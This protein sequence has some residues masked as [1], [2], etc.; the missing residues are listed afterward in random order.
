[1]PSGGVTCE[2]VSTNRIVVGNRKL[3]PT[4]TSEAA[5]VPT[6]YKM[7][8]LLMLL[9]WFSCLV[10]KA[11]MTK[12]KTKIGAIAF[13]AP[14]KRVP[15]M[16]IAVQVGTETPK[17]APPIIPITIFWIKYC[18]IRN[19]CCTGRIVHDYA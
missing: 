17:I 1:M 12:K 6:M 10:A 14:T 3:A 8:I 7:T 19:K 15:R 18:D 4:A 13:K 5:K 16:L 2:V 11:D 9:L